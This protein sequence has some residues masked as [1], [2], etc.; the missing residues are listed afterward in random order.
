[1]EKPT[2]SVNEVMDK[3]HELNLEML[4]VLETLCKK[5]DIQYYVAYGTLIGA[6][7]HQGFIPWD[8][9]I[10]LW[11]TR[12]NFE[13]LYQHRDEL[14]K[15]YPLIMP[16]IH[17]PKKYFDCVPRLNYRHM[18]IKMDEDACR[19]YDNHNNRMDLD[20]FFI[21]KTYNDWRGALQRFELV[22]L[23]ALMNAYRHKSC[24][25]RYTKG[26]RIINAISSTIGHLIPLNWMRARVA[27]VA[28]RYNDREDAHFYFRSNGLIKSFFRAIPEEYFG[29]PQ[30]LPFEDVTV[31]APQNP[32]VLLRMVYGDYMKLPPEEQRVPH[33]SSKLLKPDMFVFEEPPKFE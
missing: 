6:V 3:I 9:D 18:Y 14:P 1:M 30:R 26:R 15:D 25:E 2:M 8:N 27:K 22:V 24:F 5:Y 17:G 13:K 16:E 28:N 31:P 10:D 12:A 20:F 21:D 19:F 7:R 29:I 4:A 11:I 23:Y 32:D 33:W